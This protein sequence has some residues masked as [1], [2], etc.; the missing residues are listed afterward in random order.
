MDVLTDRDKYIGGSD[1]PII[2]NLSPFRTRF[3]LLQEKASTTEIEEKSNP[4]TEYG[5]EMESTIRDYISYMYDTDFREDVRTKGDLRYHADGYD[6]QNT[7]LEIKTTSHPNEKMYLVQLLTGMCLFECPYGILAVYDRPSDFDK[8]FDEFRLHIKRIDITDYQDLISEIEQ[9]IEKFRF[10]L[11]RVKANPFI[12][13][14]ELIP[15]EIVTKV[16]EITLIEQQLEQYK[17]L[18]KQYKTLKAELKKAMED[19]G[20]KTWTT[21]NGLKITLVMDGESTEIER[22][23]E[24]KFKKDYKDLYQE[25]LVKTTKKGKSGFVRIT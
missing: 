8:E 11:A 21:N 7:L 4:Y 18:E 2:M 1:I 24:E 15:T 12:T 3:E 16:N 17:A 22:F 25:Y 14:E 10:D 23:D 5:K 20:I 13:E 6:G 19:Y 9:A